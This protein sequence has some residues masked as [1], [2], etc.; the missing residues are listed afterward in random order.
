[1]LNNNPTLTNMKDSINNLGNTL[2]NLYNVNTITFSDELNYNIN[3]YVIYNEQ[4]YKFISE[5][6]P[7]SWNE[8]EVELVN[9]TDELKNKIYK[10][11]DNVNGNLKFYDSKIEAHSSVLDEDIAPISTTSNTPFEWYDKDG[12]V[13]GHIELQHSND[14]II[15]LKFGIRRYINS[16]WIWKHLNINVNS[17]GEISG[18]FGADGKVGGNDI[19]CSTIDLTPGVSSLTT[20]TIYFVYT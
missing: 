13:I 16:E 19:I 1:M 14:D 15:S 10:T 12:N 18:D 8:N 17:L 9:I 20:D 4:L 11:G 7:G 6:L 2:Q 5:H 3:D